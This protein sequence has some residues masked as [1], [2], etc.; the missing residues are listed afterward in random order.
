MIPLIKVHNRINCSVRGQDNG[1]IQRRK[2]EQL[3]E[4][5]TRV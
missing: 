5:V 2:R 3:S 4:G 1:Y